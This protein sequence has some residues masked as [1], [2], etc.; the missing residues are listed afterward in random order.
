MP[1]T[2]ETEV[3]RS[4]KIPAGELDGVFGENA[5]GEIKG[6]S[7]ALDF[8]LITEAAVDT[9]AAHKT[10]RLQIGASEISPD[11]FHSASKKN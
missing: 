5:A 3:K 11:I 2:P 6:S 8:T 9:N 1:K 10:R 4:V 7:A